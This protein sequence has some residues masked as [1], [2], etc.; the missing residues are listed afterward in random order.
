MESVR[1][2]KRDFP[3]AEIHW[4]TRADFAAWLQAQPEIDRV[5][6]VP[7]GS[8]FRALLEVARVLKQQQFP[9]VYDAHS[10]LRSHLASLVIAPWFRRAFGLLNFVRRPKNRLQR[11]LLFKWHWSLLPKPFKGADSYIRPLH[12][13]LKS[14][15]P[16][17]TPP[18]PAWVTRPQVEK[19][20]APLIALAPSAAWPLKRWPLSHWVELIR[21][22]P[23][24]RFVVLGGPADEFCA[25][26][27]RLYPAQVQ[28][29]AGKLNWS[30][31]CATIVQCD[32]VISGDT[33]IMHAADYLHIP[34][35]ALI[36][37][38]AFGYPAQPTSHVIE[39]ELSCKPCSKDGRG[40][41]HNEIFQKCLRQ[42][43]PHQVSQRAR[44]ALL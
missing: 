15:D 9:Y 26:L 35:L 8:G 21:R 23:D 42:L 43:T 6:S 41:C 30:E 11:W 7:T 40:Q 44:E 33:G 16:I 37:P 10:N 17:T 2:L 27:A 22:L 12:S 34:T 14:T 3:D 18:R 24:C 13:W 38:T 19:S 4:L 36:G 32:L 29:L 31:S 39:L 20:A 25:D 28:N 1:W 5:W